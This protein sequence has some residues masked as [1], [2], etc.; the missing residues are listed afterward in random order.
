MQLSQAGFPLLYLTT[1]LS[2]GSQDS[3]TPG[4]GKKGEQKG[5]RGIFEILSY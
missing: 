2:H 1:E 5:N 3:Y 4:C